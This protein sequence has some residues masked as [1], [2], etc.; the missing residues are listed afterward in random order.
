M[1]VVP[2]CMA[3]GVTLY[4]SSCSVRAYFKRHERKFDCSRVGGLNRLLLGVLRGSPPRQPSALGLREPWSRWALTHHSSRGLTVV[5]VSSGLV[6]LLGAA[7]GAAAIGHRHSA[8]RCRRLWPAAAFC[9]YCAC[10]GA[11]VGRRRLPP[12]P[13]T[14]VI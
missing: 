5:S 13:V 3:H 11:S 10:L 7:M 12:G 9:Y 6:I 8:R 4:R 1:C 2:A 14:S